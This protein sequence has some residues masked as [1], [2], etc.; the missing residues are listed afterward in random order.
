M[1]K[2]YKETRNLLIAIYHAD[3]LWRQPALYDALLLLS[4]DN[5]RLWVIGVRVPQI[6]VVCA[7][8]DDH[9]DQ[10]LG[11]RRHHSTARPRIKSS[12]TMA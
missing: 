3:M 2:I 7:I 10:G 5:D 11:Y 9:G 12:I 8:G 1:S 4:R 6:E